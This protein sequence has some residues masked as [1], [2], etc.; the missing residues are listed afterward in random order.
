[1][2]V[3]NA[4]NVV[5][6]PFG[7]ALTRL[8]SAD[9]PAVLAGDV[10][11]RAYFQTLIELI[12]AVPGDVVECG[13]GKGRSL[14]MLAV[15]TTNDRPPRR[16]WGFDSFKGFPGPAVEDEAAAA[17][18][19]FREGSLAYGRAEVRHRLISYG[20]PRDQLGNRVRLV[21]GFFPESFPEY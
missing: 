8:A 12:R 19:R 17:P 7:V 16:V 4:L 18:K 11:R 3:M 14:Y 2:G 20:L 5:L 6:R 10:Q 21:K 13:V 1:M 9:E 15:L